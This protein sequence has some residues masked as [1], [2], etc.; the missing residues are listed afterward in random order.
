MQLEIIF[1]NKRR[2]YSVIYTMHL[3]SMFLPGTMNDLT[4]QN[5]C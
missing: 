3:T 5:E 2:T 1:K 4:E